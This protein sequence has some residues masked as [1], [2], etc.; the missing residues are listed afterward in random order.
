M[1]LSGRTLAATIAAGAILAWAVW[2]LYTPRSHSL[3]DFQPDEVGRLETA[4]WKSYYARE[5]L[6]LFGELATLLRR[7]Y[8][9]PALRSYVAAYHAAHG[10]ALF[11]RGQAHPDYEKALPEVVKF[12]GGIRR[13]SAEPFDVERAARLELDWWI[14][15][16][17]RASH[18]RDDLDRKLA[19]LQAELY[20]LPAE[21]L[22]GHA[23]LRA[24]AMLLRDRA[25]ENGT[26]TGEQWA[27]IDRLLRTSWRSLWEVVHAR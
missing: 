11:Q 8:G 23:R 13:V 4:M 15:H 2:D 25:A 10:A 26:P 9:L 14:V 5:R 27:E 24:E 1:T 17:E 21:R 7:Q 20:H 6:K 18:P 12:Y 22:M 19:E 3:R 16:R